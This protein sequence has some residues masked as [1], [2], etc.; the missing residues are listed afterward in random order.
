VWGAR[1]ESSGSAPDAKESCR[2]DD[3][4]SIPDSGGVIH[5]CYLKGVGS[6]RVIDSP[7]QKCITVIVWC[8]SQDV[9]DLP[10]EAQLMFVQVGG[11]S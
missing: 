9:A 8:Q 11:C 10:S 6:L 1:G 4:A 2:G 3:R 7:N 5:G